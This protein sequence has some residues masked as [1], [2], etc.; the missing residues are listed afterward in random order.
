[1]P[2]FSENL[3]IIDFYP[4]RA[5]RACHK[6][7]KELKALQTARQLAAVTESLT[8]RPHQR[9]QNQCTPIA[10]AGAA[11]KEAEAIRELN[12]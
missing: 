8:P 6:A 1:M 3:G 5:E 9:P 12:V 10:R 4:R 11:H 7:R 2:E